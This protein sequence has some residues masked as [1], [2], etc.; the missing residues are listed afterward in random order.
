MTHHELLARAGWFTTADRILS[1]ISHDVNGRVAAFRALVQLVQLGES[2]EEALGLL[3]GEVDRLEG[4]SRLLTAL[5]DRATAGPE[6]MD[7][8]ELLEEVVRLHGKHRGLENVATELVV[9]PESPAV[10]ASRKP[11]QR[12]LLT[13]LGRIAWSV[14][15]RGGR[16]VRVSCARE[17]DGGVR[18]EAAPGP[19]RRER[20]GSRPPVPYGT[21]SGEDFGE[22]LASLLADDGA[23]VS[24]NDEGAEGSRL[25]LRFPPARAG[26]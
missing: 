8:R 15:E 2:A 6:V 19:L 4:V 14:A 10:R 7:P 9:E 12:A 11:L 18:I 22:S 1:G 20:G 21:Q 3:A 26:A 24:W 16:S 23:E 17:A 13:A 5:Q 25:R